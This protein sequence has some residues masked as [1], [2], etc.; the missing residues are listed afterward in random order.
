VILTRDGTY[1]L[2][3]VEGTSCYGWKALLKRGG[4]YFLFGK[5]LLTRGRKYFLLG[6][7]TSS[8]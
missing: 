4:K 3:R 8:A 5:A 1:F 7:E 2:L 6:V